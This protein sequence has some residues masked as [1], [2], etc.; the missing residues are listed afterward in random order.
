M[1]EYGVNSSSKL[2]GWTGGST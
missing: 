1:M 2:I